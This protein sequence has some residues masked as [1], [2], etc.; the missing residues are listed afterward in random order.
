[1]HQSICERDLK[2]DLLATQRGRCR[3]RLN[4][5]KRAGELCLSLYQRRAR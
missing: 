1:V 3:Q 2:L 5:D 4:L